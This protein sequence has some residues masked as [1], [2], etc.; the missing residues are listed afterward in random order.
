MATLPSLGQLSLQQSTAPT[1]VRFYD[2][3]ELYANI[4]DEEE[5][6][7]AEPIQNPLNLARTYGA[8]VI[9]LPQDNATVY[10]G[11]SQYQV[12]TNRRAWQAMRWPFE[13]EDPAYVDISEVA[14]PPFVD[15]TGNGDLVSWA[16]AMQ[17][18]NRPGGRQL[19]YSRQTASADLFE[20]YKTLALHAVAQAMFDGNL[21]QNSDQ[22][23]H[24][25]MRRDTLS[26]TLLVQPK[27]WRSEATRSRARR[28][29]TV[30]RIRA[31]R[32]GPERAERGVGTDPAP[33][34]R[35]FGTG[36]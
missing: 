29:E 19:H 3:E 7:T 31:R 33:P 1:D 4:F 34:Q 2:R 14:D 11:D 12:P 8:N 22:R 5:V 35:E 24:S 25:R 36:P 30:A 10:D 6:V 20:K 18:L 9:D 26:L 27:D 23:I 15:Y 17:L 16:L 13:P 32:A 21:S 28:A